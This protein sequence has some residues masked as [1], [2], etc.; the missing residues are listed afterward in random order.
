[1]AVSQDL[2]RIL[3]AAAAA[4]QQGPPRARSTAPSCSPPS[5]ATA[6]APPH[7]LLRNQG[8]TFEEAMRALQKATAAPPPPPRPAESAGPPA[9]TEDV[10]A[11]ARERINARTGGDGNLVGTARRRSRRRACARQEHHQPAPLNERFGSQPAPYLEPPLEAPAAW[12]APEE[13]AVPAVLRQPPPPDRNPQRHDEAN[14]VGA[15]ARSLHLRQA[16]PAPRMPPPQVGLAAGRFGIPPPPALPCGALTRP[17]R[18]LGRSAPQPAPPWLEPPGEL[19]RALPRPAAPPTGNKRRAARA[20]APFM[21]NWPL[22]EQGQLVENIPRN[23]RVGIPVVVEAPHRPAPTSRPL[24]RVCSGG[25]ARQCATT[26]SSPKPCR[27]GSRALDGGFRIETRSLRRSGSRTCS[28][29]RR[30]NMRAGAGPSR[31]AERGKRQIQLIVSARTVGAD[32][33]TAETALPD[34]VIDGKVGINYAHSMKR[35]MG[36]AAGSGRG[37]SARALRRNAL[38]RPQASCSAGSSASCRLV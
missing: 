38:C 9:S 8:L 22:I 5:S 1:M 24:P 3:E 15:A 28:A 30:T 4:A 26:S 25:E 21:G 33:L 18:P 11:S 31:R 6:K 14:S 36:W 19:R 7:I 10:L 34:Q 35:W 27:C 2:K 32:G 29:S 16:G 37:R 13:P 12:P 20:P 17:C 23:M